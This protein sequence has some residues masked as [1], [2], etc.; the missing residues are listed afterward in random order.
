MGIWFSNTP[1]FGYQKHI[2]IKEP[3]SFGSFFNTREGI[4]R[5]PERT[6]KEP[7]VFCSLFPQEFENTR[8]IWQSGILNILAWESWL[9]RTQRTTLIPNKGLMQ[10]LINTCPTLVIRLCFSC[11]H[12]MDKRCKSWSSL[13]F[14]TFFFFFIFF[15][16]WAFLLFGKSGRDHYWEIGSDISSWWRSKLHHRAQNS[17]IGTCR[18]RTKRSSDDL[19]IHHTN[20]FNERV[21]DMVLWLLLWIFTLPP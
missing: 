21:R 11:M 17:K 19:S 14:F 13:T 3:A 7:A 5:L 1:N 20:I 10:F 16:F 9:W 4:L 6:G 15:E 12:C 18:T 8:C 2:R